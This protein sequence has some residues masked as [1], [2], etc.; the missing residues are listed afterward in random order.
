MGLISWSWARWRGLLCSI[1]RTRPI[2]AHVAFI[3]DGNRRY[4]DQ[5]HLQKV[6]GHSFGYR[7]LLDALEWCLEL[8]VTCV[9]VY[10]FSI[11]NYRRSSEEVATL[12]Q[13]A[14]EKLMQMLQV[15]L[16]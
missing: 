8:G 12:M 4:A 16:R 15:C 14:E 5:H 3:M 13:L 11:D 10:A 9:S 2:P 1:L 7:R 6:E